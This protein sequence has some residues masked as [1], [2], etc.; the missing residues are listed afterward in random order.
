MQD[1]D[2]TM[3]SAVEIVDVENKVS[4]GIYE[5]IKNAQCIVNKPID[6]PEKTAI[7]KNYFEIAKIFF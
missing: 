4:L 1:P 2:G 6:M 7:Y 5:I 3:E